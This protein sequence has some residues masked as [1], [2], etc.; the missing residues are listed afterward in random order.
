MTPAEAI[1]RLR[2][3]ERLVD[4]EY[5]CSCGQDVL[6]AALARLADGGDKT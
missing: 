2:E 5:E 4:A 3:M 1:A 6:T